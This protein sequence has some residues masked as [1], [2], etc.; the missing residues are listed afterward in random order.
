MITPASLNIVTSNGPVDYRAKLRGR[1]VGI[2]DRSLDEHLGLLEQLRAELAQ[3]VDAYPRASWVAAPPAALSAEVAQLLATPIRN[4]ERGIPHGRMDAVLDQLRE[5]VQAKGLQFWP[6]FYFGDGDFWT[7]DRAVSVNLPW[8]AGNDLVWRVVAPEWTAA[9]VLRVLRHEYGH[10][11]GYAFEIWKRKDWKDAFGD[12]ELPYREDFEIDAGAAAD[13]PVALGRPGPVQ[14]LHYAQKHPDEDW[15]ETFAAWLGGEA[16]AQ[17]DAGSNKLRRKFDLVQAL[18]V[19][20][21]F[22]GR[23]L[24]ELRGERSPLPE[25][26][27]GDAM[28]VGQRA[29]SQHAALLRREPYLVAQVALHEA[30]F[31]GLGGAVFPAPDGSITLKDIRHAA[32]LMGFQTAA[33]AAFGSYEAWALDFRAIAAATAGWA[34]TCWDPTAARIRNFL[35][36]PDGAGVPPGMQILLA[37]DLAEHAYVG[38]YGAAGKHLYV[39][40]WFTNI[41]GQ[42]VDQL[43]TRARSVASLAPG[44]RLGMIVG[45]GGSSCARCRFVSAERT[46][47]ANLNFA[48]WNGSPALPAPAETYC[49]DNFERSTLPLEDESVPDPEPIV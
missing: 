1:L 23:P 27:V 5:E 15:A 39:A 41:D 35:V 45:P 4:L 25:G 17:Y 49:C 11:L 44:H 32:G 30:Y 31:A 43:L 10:A 3:V 40:A 28:G 13:F 6:A 33:Q 12:F 14:L 48:T 26:T 19:R 38:D 2:S 24:V 42:R 8:W 46:L 22:Y 18:V 16:P 9:D 21:A 47:C 29:F 37:L 20:G 36:E 7:A 34:L